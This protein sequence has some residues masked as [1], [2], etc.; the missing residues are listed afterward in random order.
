MPLEVDALGVDEPPAPPPPLLTCAL[1]AKPR[2]PATCPSTAEPA[3]SGAPP[4]PA[5]AS[6]DVLELALAEKETAPA[7]VRS[8]RDHDSAL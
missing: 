2:S 4:A 5:I 8:R 1:D 3:E 7:E 6:E